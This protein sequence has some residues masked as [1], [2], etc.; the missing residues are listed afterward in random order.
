MRVTD[1]GVGLA[2]E[3]LPRLTE[4]F[5]R[6]DTHRSREQGGTGLGLAIVRDVAEIYGGSGQGNLGQ[7]TAKDGAAH[8][9]L[10]PLATIMLQYIP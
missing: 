9:V 8:I 1:A 7:V 4:R 5:Y 3:H 10:P 6:V 2:R